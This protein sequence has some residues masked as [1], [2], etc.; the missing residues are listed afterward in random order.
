MSSPDLKT[1]IL[2]TGEAEAKALG[3]YLT[4]YNSQLEIIAAHDKSAL[5]AACADLKPGTR[6]VSFC[7]PVIVPK[8]Y[9]DAIDCGCYNFHPGPPG[10]PGRYP[11]GFAL[12][13]GAEQFGATVHV[14][15]ERVDEGPINAAEWFPVPSNCELETLDTLA[16]E[17]LV[18]LFKTLAK[19]LA[20]DA[21]PLPIKRI[22]WSGTKRSKADC[23]ALC[24]LDECMTPEDIAKRTRACGPH[25]TKAG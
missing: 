1:I 7:S 19:R 8:P 6:L 21:S 25:L 9:L 10:Y 14:M 5:S 13:E 15:A 18:K 11:S 2:L 4:S 23:E 22:G 17:T 3:Q 12:Y 24:T 20:T 16:F